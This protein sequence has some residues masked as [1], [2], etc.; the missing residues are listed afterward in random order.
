MTP[1]WYWNF[2]YVLHTHLQVT[3]HHQWTVNTN[4]GCNQWLSFATSALKKAAPVGRNR[5]LVACTSM[6]GWAIRW[7]KSSHTKASISA[8]CPL[9][10]RL[11]SRSQVA[12][13]VTHSCKSWR[14][15]AYTL[16]FAAPESD[17]QTFHGKGDWSS[18]PQVWSVPSSLLIII[19]LIT[20]YYR[21]NDSKDRPIFSRYLS[22]GI[23]CITSYTLRPTGMHFPHSLNCRDC[24]KQ[25]IL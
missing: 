9:K 21:Q 14:Q 22:P 3:T 10:T 17:L 19:L 15:H 1:N 6:C 25:S 20:D 16:T 7:L 24:G 8:S 4:T 11:L 5:S 18:L 13:K 23:Q 2:R 12:L